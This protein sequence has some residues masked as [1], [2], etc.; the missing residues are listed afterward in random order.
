MK[1][2]N[3]AF[4]TELK[5]EIAFFSENNFSFLLLYNDKKTNIDITVGLL[6]LAFYLLISITYLAMLKIVIYSIFFQKLIHHFFKYFLLLLS[7]VK[8]CTI[9]NKINFLNYHLS[10][11]TNSILVLRPYSNQSIHRWIDCSFVVHFHKKQQY[12]HYV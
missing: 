11:V 8:T 6:F 4:F 10:L 9:T 2:R 3:L 12:F 5:T 7:I 1:T